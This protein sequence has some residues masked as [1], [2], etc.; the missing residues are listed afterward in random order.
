ML[1]E[2]ARPLAPLA[3]RD[4]GRLAGVAEREKCGM[5]GSEANGNRPASPRKEMVGRTEVKPRPRPNWIVPL[6][7]APYLELVRRRHPMSA[8]YRSKDVRMNDVAAD[9]RAVGH[10]VKRI[11]RPLNDMRR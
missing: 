11:A 2:H 10:G 6:P 1:G 3:C 4:P 5:G 8:K 7:A 9:G